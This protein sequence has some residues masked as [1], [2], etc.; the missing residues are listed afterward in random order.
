MD[1]L[2]ISPVKRGGVVTKKDWLKGTL[3]IT[4]EAIWLTPDGMR[5]PLENI[6]GV[7][8]ETRKVDERDE[9]V[10]AVNH[11]DRN[12]ALMSLIRCNENAIEMLEGYL[13][14]FAHKYKTD[15]ELSEIEKQLISLIY[16]GLD[17]FSIMS[18]LNLTYEKLEEYSNNL[19]D[20]GLAKVK[21]MVKELE[22][23]PQGMK[24]MLENVKVI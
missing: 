7:E 5:I 18:A 8:H 12:E 24:Y 3:I 11:L 17:L 14:T 20:L 19:L 23:T 16:N 9:K 21:R 6:T 1:A 4:N 22:L 10:F 2:F 15:V 13:T